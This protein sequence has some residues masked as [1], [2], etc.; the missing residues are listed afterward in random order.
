MKN[1]KK[2]NLILIMLFLIIFIF[3]IQY[4]KSKPSYQ[5]SWDNFEHIVNDFP[6]Y[7]KDNLVK[8]ASKVI[9]N[10][11][12]N[13]ITFEFITDT[14]YDQKWSSRKT[15]LRHLDEVKELGNMIDTSFIAVGGD[16]VDGYSP[17]Y[18]SIENLNKTVSELM[19]GNNM[20]VFLVKG[21]HD[22]NT[23]YNIRNTPRSVDNV[24]FPKEFYNCTISK[25]KNNVEIAA[26]KA[27][28]EVLLWYVQRGKDC[29]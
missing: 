15:A 27:I 13:T 28:L 8:I 9:D 2:I 29:R 26:M 24:I 4:T 19:Y 7:S 16:I 11:N 6:S 10:R 21:N 17:K 1:N 22:D 3:S 12:S 25:I 18:K 5:Y 20:N 14:H 23:Y